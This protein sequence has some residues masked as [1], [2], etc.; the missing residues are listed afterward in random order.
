MWRDPIVEEVRKVRQAYA[1]RFHFDLWAMYDDL[2]AREAIGGQQ[3]ILPP[4]Q[5]QA[6]KGRVKAAPRNRDST[7]SRRG[8]RAR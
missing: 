2:K 6:G 8:S 5:R 7:P 4:A 3:V 1:A